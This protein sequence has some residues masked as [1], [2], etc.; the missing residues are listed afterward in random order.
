MNVS[1]IIIIVKF[2][3][4]FKMLIKNKGR[5]LVLVLFLFIVCNCLNFTLA[6]VYYIVARY[7]AKLAFVST[8]KFQI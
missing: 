5:I 1:F 7:L 2:V 8:C 6:Y 4:V 3:Y